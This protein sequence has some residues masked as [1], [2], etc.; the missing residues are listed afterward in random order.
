V[1]EED[2]ARLKPV[3]GSEH[4]SET[5]LYDYS[6]FL[7][8]ISLLALGGILSLSQT[9]GLRDV[10]AFN[11]AWSIGAVIIGGISAFSVS[12]D[13]VTSRAKGR[14]P[15]RWV[16]PTMSIALAGIGLGLGG[17]VHIFWKAIT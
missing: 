14:E 8:T 5:L 2:D 13:I 15:S 10:K 6:K 7:T 1:I 9:D 4:Y 16:R 3:P 11:L 12:H 17:F